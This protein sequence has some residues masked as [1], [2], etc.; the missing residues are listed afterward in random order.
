MAKNIDFQQILQDEASFQ[1]VRTNPKLT[2]N[3]KLTVDG[4]DKMWLNSIDANEELSKAL[5]KRVA[6]DPSVSLPGNMYTFFDN[7]TTPSEIVFQLKE[8]FDSTK[9]STDYKDQ[10]DFD[11]YFSGVNYLPS[12][13]YE[14]KLSYFA[15]IYLREDVPEYFVIFKIKDPLNNPIDQM[16]ATYPYDKENYIKELFKKSTIIKTFDLRSTTKVGEFLRRHVN[17]IKYNPL[18][19][20]YD[21]DTLTTFGGILYDSG[22]FGQRGENLYDFYNLCF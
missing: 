21:E 14:E 18:Q 15:P 8:S 7:G 11:H 16:H 13:R 19:V 10:Y 12:R 17:D 5:Y 9:T 3:V 2:G 4:N 20:S 6:V 1:L 22:V